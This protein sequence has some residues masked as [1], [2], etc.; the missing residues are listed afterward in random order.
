MHCVTDFI[1]HRKIFF[2]YY[3]FLPVTLMLLCASIFGEKNTLIL[4]QLGKMAGSFPLLTLRK[5]L[6]TDGHIRAHRV[7]YFDTLK[8]CV[9]YQELWKL[10]F[11][12]DGKFLWNSFEPHRS[13]QT[14]SVIIT[15]NWTT[16][17]EQRHSV[18]LISIKY[19]TNFICQ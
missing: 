5:V 9:N 8:D 10:T 6:H 11:Q 19:M 17:T 2:L 4:K 14:H 3:L 7:R 16:T 18:E 1:V 12:S 15:L 13:T